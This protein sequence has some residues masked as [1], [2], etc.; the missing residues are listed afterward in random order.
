MLLSVIGAM[1][2]FWQ[3]IL[4]VRM[5][6]PCVI[7]TIRVLLFSPYCEES[8]GKDLLDFIDQILIIPIL[9]A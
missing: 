6:F 1:H 5:V 9:L 4:T 8:V 3:E 7:L 2:L